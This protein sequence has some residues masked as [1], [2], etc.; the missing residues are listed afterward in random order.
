MSF[1]FVK[2]SAIESNCICWKWKTL[3][4]EIYFILG[5]TFYNLHIN[6][7]YKKN[8]VSLLKTAPAIPDAGPLVL[9]PHV[10]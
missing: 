9:S 5:E 10:M 1:S 2:N 4:Y 7:Y 6:T 8:A 3:C